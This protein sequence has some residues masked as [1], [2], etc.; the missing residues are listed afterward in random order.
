MVRK[1][2]KQFSEKIILDETWQTADEPTK[3]LAI[4]H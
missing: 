3:L 1:G 2:A 4:Q